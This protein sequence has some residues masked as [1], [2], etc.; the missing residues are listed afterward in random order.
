[1]I[2]D[3]F[4]AGPAEQGADREAMHHARRRMDA[5]HGIDRIERVAGIVHIVESAFGI[6]ATIL[7]EIEKPVRLIEQPA[8]VIIARA[9]VSECLCLLPDA[10]AFLPESSATY[11]YSAVRTMCHGR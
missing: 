1:M 8:P 4:R 7:E 11:A 10:H 5:A 2:D 3:A 9:P 6:D